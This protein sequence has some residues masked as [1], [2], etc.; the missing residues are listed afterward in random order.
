MTTKEF[1]IE[2][3]KKHYCKTCVNFDRCE[4]KDK[5]HVTQ[6]SKFTEPM[7]VY[8]VTQ[9]LEYQ[10][11]ETHYETKVLEAFDSKLKAQAFI[12][13][14]PEIG[15]TH[16]EMFVNNFYGEVYYDIHEMEVK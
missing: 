10:D 8:V 4:Y 1:N 3:N 11:F 2:H 9:T 6:C 7:M 13:S 12:D 5:F 15:D 16:I 14:K